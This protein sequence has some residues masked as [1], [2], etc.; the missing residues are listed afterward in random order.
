MA[1]AG[2][3]SF[4]SARK[5]ETFRVLNPTILLL[6]LM[7]LC[8]HS[9]AATNSSN[10]PSQGGP[11]LNTSST[12][13]TPSAAGSRNKWIWITAAAAVVLLI[14]AY[15]IC[16]YRRRKLREKMLAE[17]M[18]SDTPIEMNDIENEGNWGHDHLTVH[19]MASIVTA[20]NNFSLRN[21]LGQGG[22]GPVY[23][24]KLSEGLEVAVKRLS[25]TSGQG[26]IEF[27]N[28]LILI[29]NLQHRNLVRLLGCCIHGEEKMLVYEYMPNKSLDS[30]IFD[31][32]KKLFLDWNKRFNIIEGIA[33]G[34]LYLHKY[35]RVRIVH[36]DLK[37]GNILLDENLSPKI[38]DFGMARIF[39]SN[40]SEASTNKLVG[41]YGYMSPEYAMNGT[42]STKSDVFSFGVMVL[43]IVSGMKN[44]G[45][46]QL[47]PP[48]NL[49]GYASKLWQEGATLQLM[50]PTLS[51][52]DSNKDQIIRC[53][54][55]GLL[56]IEYNAHDRPTMSDV[57]TMLTSEG[58]QLPTPKQPAVTVT[59]PRSISTKSSS[60][61]S[62]SEICSINRVTMTAISGR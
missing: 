25:K 44:Y 35:S 55:I 2:G 41:T 18:P 26:I 50:D 21:K 12:A 24:G 40:E 22:F 54:N 33:Q 57:I 31:E 8:S 47:D 60:S 61:T 38:S 42:F 6:L 7:L 23:K 48:I 36:R 19:S 51:K 45:I 27:R 17:F 52:Y 56:C 53:I 62:D 4:L 34:L 37:V 1:A 10:V 39:S 29:A 32:S 20:T 13:P 5:R 59:R 28:E 9:L 16:Q 15:F 46:I 3:S 14:A 49:V 43:E 11:A 30:F 58:T